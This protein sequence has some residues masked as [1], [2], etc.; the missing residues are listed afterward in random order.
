MVEVLKRRWIRL[1][2]LRPSARSSV[3]VKGLREKVELELKKLINELE[4][5][6]IFH[7]LTS[8]LWLISGPSS[9]RDSSPDPRTWT[10]L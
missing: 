6:I 10:L 4:D 9:L 2:R 1:P 8:A 5:V 3:Q 7:K